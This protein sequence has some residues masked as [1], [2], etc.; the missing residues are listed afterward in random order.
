MSRKLSVI[1]DANNSARTVEI[2][3]LA[4][5][6]KDGAA[7]EMARGAATGAVSTVPAKASDTSESTG[8]G[9]SPGPAGAM[10]VNRVEKT[11]SEQ[12]KSRADLKPKRRSRM[13]CMVPL[14][15]LHAG[16]H[17]GP[18]FGLHA[19]RA[20]TVLPRRQR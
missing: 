17:V 3:G 18:H 16:L 9:A 14:T 4:D 7:G 19:S 10:I 6:D 15:I 2:S 5:G 1:M 13:F 8:I 11:I 12:R 20:A